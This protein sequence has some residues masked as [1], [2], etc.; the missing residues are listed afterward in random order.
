[1][2]EESGAATVFAAFS[3]AALLVATVGAVIIGAAVVVRHRAQ[4][5]ADMAALAA[6]GRLPAGRNHACQQA[7]AVGIAM[8][9]AVTSCEVDGLDVV[10]TCMVRL[11]VWP[12]GQARA[13]SRAGPD[14]VR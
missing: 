5:A 4:A 8:G 7:D 9:A 13:A 11:P 12:G 6:A 1:V 14:E 10:V 3:V 2:Y